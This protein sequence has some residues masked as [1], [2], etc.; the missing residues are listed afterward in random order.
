MI[1]RGTFYIHLIE[2]I[3][4][5]KLLLLRR[6]GKL[7]SSVSL[8]ER[9]P[10]YTFGEVMPIKQLKQLKPGCIVE[11]LEFA[12]DPD[13][14]IEKI[15]VLAARQGR[16]YN[17]YEIHGLIL[18]PRQ[19]TKWKGICE[20]SCEIAHWSEDFKIISD[21]VETEDLQEFLTSEDEELRGFYNG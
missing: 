1:G 16:H 5:V 7:S 21:K 18:S 19:E 12:Q 14:H 20:W 2:S 13:E 3:F 4:I 11:V 9:E 8:L 6:V 10:N 17:W 15:L